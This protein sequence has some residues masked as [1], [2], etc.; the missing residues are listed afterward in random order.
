V[1]IHGAGMTAWER[2]LAGGVV[3]EWSAVGEMSEA[4]HDS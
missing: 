3:G 1:V 4:E 2:F